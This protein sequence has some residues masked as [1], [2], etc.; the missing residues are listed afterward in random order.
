MK[1]VLFSGWNKCHS[2][3]IKISARSI[4]RKPLKH[5]SSIKY[6]QHTRASLKRVKT[7]SSPH[8]AKIHRTNPASFINFLSIINKARLWPG[9]DINQNI[10]EA[11]KPS[12]ILIYTTSLWSSLLLWWCGKIA[13][14][15]NHGHFGMAMTECKML[16]EVRFW[17]FSEPVFLMLHKSIYLYIF[18]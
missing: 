3:I 11:Q 4:G 6:K 13:V 7:V 1:P 12:L 15:L 10:I 2:R 14:V 5:R 9:C 8:N 18:S 16:L 17:T